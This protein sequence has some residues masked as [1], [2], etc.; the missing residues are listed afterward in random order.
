[1]KFTW[2]WLLDHLETEKSLQE[3]LTVLPM[4]GIEIENLE[5]KSEKLKDFIVAK[6]IDSKQ[7]P[8]ADRLK[9]LYIDDGSNSSHQVICGAPNAK[10]I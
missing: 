1:M 7:H 10:K 3:V 6:V 2:H 9:I 8:N 5:D 4:L